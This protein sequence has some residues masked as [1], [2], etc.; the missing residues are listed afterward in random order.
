MPV[1]TLTDADALSDHWW[2]RPG[3]KPGRIIY[4]WHLTFEHATE[5]HDLASD[6]QARLEPVP[7][8]WL[9]LTMQGV[10]YVDEIE[11][12]Q[13]DAIVSAVQ[14]RVAE[15]PSF[16][17]TFARAVILGE[18]IV[19]EP[20]P[21]EPIHDLYATIRR[22]I[23]DVAGRDHLH[24][25]PEQ[26]DGFRAHVSIAYSHID[27]DAR[28]YRE[29]LDSAPIKPAN[30]QVSEAALIRQDRVLAPEWVYRWTTEATAHFRG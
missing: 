15:V 20:E 21:A 6:L 26:K 2:P 10:G 28:P 12:E 30:V 7:L 17:V 23:A 11:Q 25:G 8:Q 24:A 22:G 1:Q 14:R 13:V 16:D 27:T 18:A 29:A 19:V 5:L 9:H 4:T 3:W